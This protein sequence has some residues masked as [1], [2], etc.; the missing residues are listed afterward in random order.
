MI[1]ID[2]QKAFD[3]IDQ[4]ILLYKLLPI[5]F[6]K[7]TIS[8]YESYLAER[9]FTV[10]VANRVLK[11]SKNSCGV[12]QG[13]ILGPLLLLIY[14]NDMSEAVECDLYLYADDSCLLFQDKNVNKIKKQLTKDLNNIC[15]WFVDNKLSIHFGED[16]TKSIL[17][18]SKR[19][20]K[21]V[22]LDIRYKDIKIKQYK[23]VNYLGCMLDESMSGE[24][25]A[26]TVTERINSRL[27]FLHRKDWFLDVH[28]RRLLCNAL[29][30]PHFDYAC[31]AW[32][33][34]LPKK[35]KDKLQVT[36]NKCI[37]FCLK[38]QS[39]EHISNEHF[40]KLNW[41]PINQMFQQCV[42]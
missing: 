12:P 22:E 19:N 16:K 36:Q 33:P 5:S 23:H 8:W 25:M 21:L 1:L 38:L 9:H 30:Q 40:H 11:F 35:L 20:L 39:R 24:T 17:F 26:L 27:K 34:N 14:V 13:S 31:T 15:D 42:T 29:I 18:S 2:L 32:Y 3:T 6:S 4:K 37:R 41:L 28:L 10:E 7:N